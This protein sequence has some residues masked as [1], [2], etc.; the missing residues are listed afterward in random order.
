MQ[1]AIREVKNFGNAVCFG[2]HGDAMLESIRAQMARFREHDIEPQYVLMNVDSY[3]EMVAFAE[4]NAA[5]R[6]NSDRD[7][8]NGLPVIICEGV[9][10]PTVT[11]SPGELS[12]HGLL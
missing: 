10:E 8:V 4:Q 1:S 9:R 3:H 5:A 7:S 6:H 11:A 12:K 2:C